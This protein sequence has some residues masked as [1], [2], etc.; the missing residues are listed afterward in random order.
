MPLSNH[1]TGQWTRFSSTSQT[2]N[3]GLSSALPS[4]SITFF[5]FQAPP[6][7]LQVHYLSLGDT[8]GRAEANFLRF[9]VEG[10]SNDI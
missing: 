9:S 10:T 7:G 6:T 8:T 5:L 2:R 4:S 3:T 1:S